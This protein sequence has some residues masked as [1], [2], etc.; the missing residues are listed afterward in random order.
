MKDQ[1][2]KKHNAQYSKESQVASRPV[3]SRLS[4]REALSKARAQINIDCF[5]EAD[6]DFANEIIF[7]IAEVYMLWDSSPVKIAGE[8]IDGYILKQVFEELHEEHVKLVIDN[9]SRIDYYV[10]YKKAYIRT[11]LYNS[12]FEYT[13]HFENLVNTTLYR[14]D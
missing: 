5:S 14:N 10:N 3:S 9:F 4:F 13:A 8:Q 2:N 12:V 7:N 6:K 11:A 1:E